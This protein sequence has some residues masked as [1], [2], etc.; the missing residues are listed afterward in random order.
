MKPIRT[1]LST[2]SSKALFLGTLAASAA[3]PVQSYAGVGGTLQV[4]YL[5]SGAANTVAGDFQGSKIAV[6]CTSFSGV[7]ETLQ[8]VVRDGGGTQRANPTINIPATGTLTI[9]IQ[10][11]FTLT[12]DL[13]LA[14]NVA[15]MGTLAVLATSVNISCTAEVSVGS[16]ST[17][18][19]YSLHGPRFNPIPGTQE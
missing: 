18:Q 10:K 16:T 1:I 19:A 4:L 12:E 13:N 14:V 2:L 5:W 17:I 7:T 6:H 11:I 8:I 9:V 15:M 3:L